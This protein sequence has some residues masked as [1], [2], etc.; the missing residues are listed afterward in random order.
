MQCFALQ[1]TNVETV[2]RL[3]TEMGT[4][5]QAPGS[6]LIRWTCPEIMGTLSQ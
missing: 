3:A 6:V 1:R 2:G 5:A 4:A